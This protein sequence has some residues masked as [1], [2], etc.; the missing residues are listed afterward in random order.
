MARETR[1]RRIDVLSQSKRVP[2]GFIEDKQSVYSDCKI[3]KDWTKP[4]STTTANVTPRLEQLTQPKTLSKEYVGDRPSPIWPVAPAAMN[5]VPTARLESLS[6]SKSFHQ[7]YEPPKSVYSVVTNAAKSANASGRVE[8][9]AKPKNST[10]LPTN[11]SLWDW[12]EWEYSVS[13][14]AKSAVPSGHTLSLAMPKK[15]HG[16]YEQCR[17]VQWGISETTLKALPSLRVQQ[18][19]RPKSRSQFIEHYD[20]SAYKVTSAA[21]H[22]QATPRLEELCLPL[23]RKVRQKKV[24]ASS[25]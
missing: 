1:Q 11:Q 16:S 23:P 2:E 9:L 8:N 5:T 13:Q 3:P 17:E 21:K 18:L 7:D 25:S 19:A 24:L 22:A 12:S 6:R 15:P 4:Q 14:A 10:A 20:E